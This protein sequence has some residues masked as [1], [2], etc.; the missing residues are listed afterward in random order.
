M[1][2][3]LAVSVLIFLFVEGCATAPPQ[4]TFA[5]ISA[6]NETF[7]VEQPERS[8]R[9]IIADCDEDDGDES[10]VEMCEISKATLI[11]LTGAIT[12]LQDDREKRIDS[13]NKS[14]DNLTHC[15]YANS[16]L[17]RAIAVMDERMQNLDITSQV[18]QLVTFAGCGALLWAK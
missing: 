10:T 7:K 18:K 15:E 3:N 2:L 14:I 5:D 4:I 16:K 6:K 12:D 9:N 11:A 8:S 17:E 13:Y 1:K